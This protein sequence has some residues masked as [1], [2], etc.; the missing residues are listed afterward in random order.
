[1]TRA[2]FCSVLVSV[3]L[4]PATRA[5]DAPRF[6]AADVHSSAPGKTF[7]DTFMQGPF[8]GGARFEIRK[9]TMLDLIRLGWSIQPDK[10]IGGP[11][12]IGSNRFDIL[13]R[14]PVNASSADLRLMLQS[15][16][17]ERFSLKVHND[18]KPMPAFALIVAP[19][20]KPRLKEADGSGDTG[21]KAENSA[22]GEGVGRLMMS[23]PDGVVTTIGI[24]PGGLV[25]YNCRNMTMTAFAAG[26]GGFVGANF[27][28]NPISDE[29]ELKGA[30]NFEFRYSFN[31]NGPAMMN[32][33][34]AERLPYADA[35]EK[36]L[37][38]RL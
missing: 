6:E 15:L 31:L 32:G 22:S 34:A 5:A 30:W 27:G 13:A 7:R 16:L 28:P 21:C 29:T 14:A 8:V 38:L 11:P 17:S 4:T 1:M 23:G 2:I 35:L 33:A 36:Q 24:L 12:S 19:A 25:Q 18:K 9:A 26:L 3:C 37:G 20:R 10:I